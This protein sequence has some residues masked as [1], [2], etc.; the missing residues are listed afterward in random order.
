MQRNREFANA[1]QGIF[2]DEQGILIEGSRDRGIAAA[3]RR[4]NATWLGTPIPA[5][6]KNLDGLP[7]CLEHAPL[8]AE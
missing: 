2:F 3:R 6:A 8:A 7:K 5:K 1:Y 4:P